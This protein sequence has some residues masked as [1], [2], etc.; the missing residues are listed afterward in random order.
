[1]PAL[2]AKRE[3]IGAVL[4]ALAENEDVQDE[5]YKALDEFKYKES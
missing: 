1:M 3:T 5:I 2:S 4:E